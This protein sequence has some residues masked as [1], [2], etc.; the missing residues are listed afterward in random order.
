[1]D[2]SMLSD[3]NGALAVLSGAANVQG[4]GGEV[5]VISAAAPVILAN[6]EEGLKRIDDNIK[7][8]RR[9]TASRVNAKGLRIYL[10]TEALVRL[11]GEIT[12]E[13]AWDYSAQVTKVGDIALFRKR[14]QD[15]T[16]ALDKA[17]LSLITTNAEKA[18]KSEANRAQP[19]ALG[20]RLTKE[21]ELASQYGMTEADFRK[22]VE[23]VL[24][25]SL[26][27]V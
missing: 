1:M 23:S 13:E 3:L 27:T 12:A 16:D 15:G 19:E 20:K 4:K 24:E 6:G 7:V 2:E 10:A 17:Q 25:G 22:M 9:V 5:F 21:W 18:D 8:L 14:V 11:D 26:V